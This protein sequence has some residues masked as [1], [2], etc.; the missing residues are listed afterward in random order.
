MI[1]AEVVVHLDQAIEEAQHATKRRRRIR[2]L[3][4]ALLL[5]VR[6]NGFHGLHTRI[7]ER[8]EAVNQL[9]AGLHHDWI[10]EHERGDVAPF[11]DEGREPATH[12]KTDDRDVTRNAARARRRPRARPRTSPPRTWSSC[13]RPWSR[14]RAD[15]AARR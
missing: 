13:P 1:F 8:L 2:R 14:V 10:D 12:R 9:V 4:A 5:D 11:A 6:A 15:E 7:D 3:D